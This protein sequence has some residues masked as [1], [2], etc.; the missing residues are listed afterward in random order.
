L[1]VSETKPTKSEIAVFYPG[2]SLG[3]QVAAWVERHPECSVTS[4][5][6]TGPAGIRNTLRTADLALLDA[7]FDAAQMMPAFAQA[8]AKLGAA[9]VA[10]YTETMHEW[11]ELA[12]RIRGVLLLFGPLSGEQWEGFF[13]KM[14]PAN[15]RLYSAGFVMP[16]A[17][18]R[19]STGSETRPHEHSGKRAPAGFRRPKTGVK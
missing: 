2:D 12:V 3:E 13:E 14:L 9:H 17:D 11:L 6:A 18:A 7:T 16:R 4:S 19:A 5:Y 1:N 15:R 10:V 8:V